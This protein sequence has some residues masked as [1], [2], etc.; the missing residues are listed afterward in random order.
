MRSYL[1]RSAVFL[2]LLMTFVTACDS[3]SMS[4]SSDEQEIPEE[5]AIGELTAVLEA[6]T[7]FGPPHYQTALRAVCTTNG[8]TATIAK[9]ELVGPF[10]DSPGFELL[11]T[12]SR[13][14]GDTLSI[15]VSKPGRAQLTC[16]SDVGHTDFASLSF[17]GLE[18]EIDLSA[19]QNVEMLVDEESVIEL[20]DFMTYAD[21][22]YMVDDNPRPDLELRIEQDSTTGKT[23][24][25]FLP[26]A[27]R[28]WLG[29][30][31]NA[32]NGFGTAQDY[33]RF[34]SRRPAGFSIWVQDWFDSMDV[35]ARLSILDTD[36]QAML[37]RDVDGDEVF[38]DYREFS[39]PIAGIRVEP[40]DPEYFPREVSVSTDMVESKGVKVPILTLAP[41]LSLLSLE[42]DPEAQCLNM[43]RGLMFSSF[44]PEDALQGFHNDGL[45]CPY[46]LMVDRETDAVIPGI[47]VAAV[48]AA[49][50]VWEDLGIHM[51]Y[52]VT[53]QNQFHA[54]NGRT[55]T[56]DLGRRV[57]AGPGTILYV[58]DQRPGAGLTVNYLTN[59]EE[60]RSALVFLPVHDDPARW[61][62]QLEMVRIQTEYALA[63]DEQFMGWT[64]ERQGAFLREWIVHLHDYRG[65]NRGIPP[66]AAMEDVFPR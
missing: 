29:I 41:C 45:V 28:G 50:T 16:Q 63:S 2:F 56:D 64:R 23:R 54:G 35:A 10:D 20:T 53:S 18:P 7:T 66:G 58:P 49:G 34:R 38:F 57:A 55:A 30:E 11:D 12:G 61:T 6:D 39:S 24:V 32:E 15:T 59:G 43:T 40:L 14:V 4:G 8:G 48:R 33:I 46:F 65:T 13:S 1:L 5:P 3:D 26:T 36:G 21:T 25:Y 31:F 27:V 19:F 51:E 9:A 44:Y 62:E 52:P 42:S 60:V 47:W 22:L 17:G 37:E